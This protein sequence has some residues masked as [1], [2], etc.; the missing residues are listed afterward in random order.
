MI[1]DFVGA[2]ATGFCLFGVLLIVN[3]V[4]GRRLGRWIYPASVALG[5]IGYTV[6]AEY[7]WPVRTIE[8]SPQMRL[9]SENEVSVFYRPWTYIW[10]QVT[11]L[12]AIDA[13]H[14]LVHPEQ[15]ALVLT[16]VV[17]I[18]RWPDRYDDPAACWAS[19]PERR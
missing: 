6:W 5:M 11:R 7:T 18:G 16:Q 12:R 3:R 14:T 4:T 10:P 19:K 2:I 9:A 17:F 1:I 8:A 15:D 13:S